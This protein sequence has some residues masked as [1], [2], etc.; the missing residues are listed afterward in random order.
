[1]AVL[2]GLEEQRVTRGRAGSV[3]GEPGKGVGQGPPMGSESESNCMCITHWL[4]MQEVVGQ[5][6]RTLVGQ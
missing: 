3:N 2:V 5:K 1:M 6:P 4:N